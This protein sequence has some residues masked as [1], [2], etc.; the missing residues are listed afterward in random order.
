MVKTRIIWGDQN[1]SVSL[2]IKL[3]YNK[4]IILYSTQ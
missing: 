1:G 2:N 3:N 4:I